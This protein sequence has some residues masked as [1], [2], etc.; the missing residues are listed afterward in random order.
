MNY[1]LPKCT[2]TEVPVWTFL[3]KAQCTALHHTAAL[4]CTAQQCT[5]LY[6]TQLYCTKLYCNVLHCTAIL[7]TVLWCTAWHCTL[8]LYCTSSCHGQYTHHFFDQSLTTIAVFLE[9]F[10]CLPT[11]LRSKRILICIL[12][13]VEW[14]ISVW[15]PGNLATIEQ[16]WSEHH[17]GSRFCD[18]I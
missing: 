17:C 8:E 18:Q 2:L 9:L 11:T 12:L 15:F 14:N 5:E 16:K 6:C 10:T 3:R 4:N 7:F 13:L 1:A